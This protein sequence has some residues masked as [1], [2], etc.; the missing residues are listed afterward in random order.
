MVQFFLNCSNTITMPEGPSIVILKELVQQFNGQ[1]VLEVSGNTKID[2]D[3]LLN[4]KVLEFKSWGKHF[5]IVF[6]GFALRIHFLLF[7]TYR[8]NERK[9]TQPRLGL[10]F[11]NGELN[12]YACGL[13]VIEGDL[14]TVYDWAADVMSDLWDPGKAKQKLLKQPKMLACDALLDQDIFAGSGNIIKNEVLFRIHTHPESTIGSMQEI[15]LDALIKEVRDYSFDFFRW[16]K[17]YE[18]K[19]NWL[20]HT[21]RISHRCNLAFAKQKLGKTNRKS[22]YCESCQK[23]YV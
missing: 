16:K 14:D 12:M 23:L 17:A 22:F 6:E 2:K 19:K 13:Q 4:K 9:E 7:G 20:A 1:E 5:L 3:R 15:Q 21:K 8:I 18:L 11:G 10:V